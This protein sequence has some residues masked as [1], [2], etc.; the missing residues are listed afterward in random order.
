MFEG[1]VNSGGVCGNW[2]PS[3]VGGGCTGHGGL[4]TVFP[5]IFVLYLNHLPC[6]VSSSSSSLS[7]CLYNNS[8]NFLNNI[9]YFLI[10]YTWA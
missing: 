5:N 9:Y 3:G 1:G 6:E 7:F 4:A 10:D 8:R 2:D